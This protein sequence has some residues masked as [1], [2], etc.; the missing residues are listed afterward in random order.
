MCFAHF[1]FP[2]I[3]HFLSAFPFCRQSFFQSAFYCPVSSFDIVCN[4]FRIFL[5]IALHIRLALKR[6]KNTAH[7]LI[8]F[9]VQLAIREIILVDIFPNFFFSPFEYRV[10]II[11]PFVITFRLIRLSLCSPWRFFCPYSCNNV[12]PPPPTSLNCLQ[13]YRISRDGKNVTSSIN[14]HIDFF[15]FNLFSQTSG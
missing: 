13:Q 15:G 2:P 5:H 11:M 7:T 8:A 12:L 9:I 3:E 1:A 6:A 14:C 10:A 4:V